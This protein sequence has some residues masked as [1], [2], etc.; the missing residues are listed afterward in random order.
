MAEEPGREMPAVA[1]RSG[2]GKVER[3]CR[4]NRVS[5]RGAR[6]KARWYGTTGGM[7]MRSDRLNLGVLGSGGEDGVGAVVA[8]VAVAAVAIGADAVAVVAGGTAFDTPTVQ[9]G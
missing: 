2:V 4:L 3:W 5:S 1:R 7:L 6:P 8:V 9:K